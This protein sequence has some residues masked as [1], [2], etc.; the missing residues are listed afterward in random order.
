MNLFRS[1]ASLMTASGWICL[2]AEGGVITRAWFSDEPVSEGDPDTA[3]ISALQQLQ[4]YLNGERKS[5]DL[6]LQP[7]GTPFQQKVWKALTEVKFGTTY[8]YKEFAT[9]IAD[10]KSPRAVATAIG[11]NP[12]AILIPCHRIIGSKGDLTGYAWG[13]H[14]KE[15]LLNLEQGA[16]MPSLF[17]S[18]N[19]SANG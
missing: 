17:E 9:K 10:A 2:E 13:L 19:N 1:T 5:F 4:E 15:W 6:P 16:Y 7:A 12:V 14:R 3:L 8:S 11:A 18:E